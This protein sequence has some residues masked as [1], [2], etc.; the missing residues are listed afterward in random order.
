MALKHL[1]VLKEHGLLRLAKRQLFSKL[2]SFFMK[3]INYGRSKLTSLL[4]SLV[5][6]KLPVA[7]HLLSLGISITLCVLNCTKCI[8]KYF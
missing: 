8:E 5:V 7:Y 2:E 3:G 6:D 4:A 1:P